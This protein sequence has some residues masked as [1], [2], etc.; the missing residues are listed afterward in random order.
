[1][2]NKFKNKAQGIKGRVDIQNTISNVRDSMDDK[3]DGAGVS[4]HEIV[5]AHWPRIE[6]LINDKLLE[7]VD[8]HITDEATLVVAF[9]KTY[10]KLPT[11]VRL[12]LSRGQFVDY[13]MGKKEPLLDKYLEYRIEKLK[14]LPAVDPGDA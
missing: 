8:D 11:M 14:A 9:E 10:E 6:A 2:F 4:R 1:M 3:V 7:H 12:V 5:Q 13:C